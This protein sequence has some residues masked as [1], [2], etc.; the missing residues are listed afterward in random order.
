MK[1][2]DIRCKCEQI[3]RVHNYESRREL[4]RM[5]G[6]GVMRVNHF[7]R[8]R[9]FRWKMTNFI[10]GAKKVRGPSP[11]TFDLRAHRPKTFVSL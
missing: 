7:V 5:E 4:S 9:V 3:P 10:K 2:R 8:H 11:M 6:F 1:T